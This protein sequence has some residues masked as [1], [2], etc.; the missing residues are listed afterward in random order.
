MAGQKRHPNFRSEDV[1]ILVD[2]V[3]EQKQLRAYVRA[4][5]CIRTHVCV[6][7]RACMCLCNIMHDLYAK[8]FGNQECDKNDAH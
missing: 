3:G 1:A 7:F 5:V 8:I 2:T 4:R 6:C